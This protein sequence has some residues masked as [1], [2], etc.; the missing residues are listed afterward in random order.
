M[1][2]TISIDKPSDSRGY[3]LLRWFAADGSTTSIVKGRSARLNGNA[4]RRPSDDH[5]M[6]GVRERS[7][8]TAEQVPTASSRGMPEPSAVDSSHGT[9]D[10][11][12]L[13]D[14]TAKI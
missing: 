7:M 12:W 14:V 5:P 9:R 1:R 10:W 4:M 8:T 3:A 13:A 6:E 2:A 11:R